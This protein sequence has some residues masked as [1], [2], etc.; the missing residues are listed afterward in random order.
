MRVDGGAGRRFADEDSWGG[1]RFPL[2]DVE[3]ALYDDGPQDQKR[4]LDPNDRTGQSYA[5]QNLT[6]QPGIETRVARHETV[7]L[8]RAFDSWT[9]PF[10]SGAHGAVGLRAGD[11]GQQPGDM[12]P[13]DMPRRTLR[14]LPLV[15]WDAGTAV[16]PQQ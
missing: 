14:S 3:P 1:D 13:W 15:P 12:I 11:P 8:I 2:I 7:W 10:F 4:E 16:G 5:P 6:V 9:Q